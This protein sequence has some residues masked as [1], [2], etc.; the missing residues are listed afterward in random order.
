[1]PISCSPS[2]SNTMNVVESVVSDT[3][4]CILYLLHFQI[5]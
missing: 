1:L 3:S 5:G 4:I 2:L